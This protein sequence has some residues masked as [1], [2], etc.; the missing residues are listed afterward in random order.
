[1]RC[2]MRACCRELTHPW[3]NFQRTMESVGPLISVE[4]VKMWSREKETRRSR[5]KK[6]NVAGDC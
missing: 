4:D 5:E 1:M 3:R 2:S 6:D